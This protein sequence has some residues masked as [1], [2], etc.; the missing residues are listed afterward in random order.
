MNAEPRRQGSL[1]HRAPGARLAL[2]REATDRIVVEGQPGL[3]GSRRVRWRCEAEVT[4]RKCGRRPAPGRAHE[5]PLTD[6]VGLDHGFDRIH[7][8]AH[9]DGERR[10]ADRPRKVVKGLTISAASPRQS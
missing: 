8:F 9:G 7:L 6:E 4:P 1:E 10:E 2:T 5:E 3:V